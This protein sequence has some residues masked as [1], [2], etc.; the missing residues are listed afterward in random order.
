MIEKEVI[1][2]SVNQYCLVA[3]VRP[4]RSARMIVKISA[5]NIKR[6]QRQALLN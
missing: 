5:V 2:L 1:E 4:S 3:A 6:G